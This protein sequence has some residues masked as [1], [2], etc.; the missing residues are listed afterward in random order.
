MSLLSSHERD[1]LSRVVATLSR[2]LDT[3]KA[4]G[5]VDPLALATSASA[6]NALVILIRANERALYVSHKLSDALEQMSITDPPAE[7]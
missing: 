1:A 6:L 3:C 2:E 7:D 4:F 5:H